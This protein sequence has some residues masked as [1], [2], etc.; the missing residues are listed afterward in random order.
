MEGENIHIFVVVL[1]IN[2]YRNPLEM[3]REITEYN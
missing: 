2:Y 1:F 3:D